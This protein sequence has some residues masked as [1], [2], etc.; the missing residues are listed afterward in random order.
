[1]VFDVNPGPEGSLYSGA[2]VAE[3]GG[4]A[5]FA[6]WD[7][8]THQIWG[9]TQDLE[10]APVTRLPSSIH[11]LSPIGLHVIG[12]RLLFNLDDG[13]H[14]QE[15]WVT[16]GT[17]AGTRMLRDINVGEPGEYGLPGSG[18]GDYTLLSRTGRTFFLAMDSSGRDLWSTDGTPAGTRKAARLRAGLK[19]LAGATYTRLLLWIEDAQ[20]GRELWASDGSESGASLVRDVNPGPDGSDPWNL[21]SFGSAALMSASDGVHGAELWRTDGTPAGTFLVK[22]IVPGAGSSVPRWFVAA[23]GRIYFTAF[24]PYGCSLWT[25]DGTAEGTVVVPGA[26]GLCPTQL[27]PSGRRLFFH[28]YTR[29]HGSELWALPLER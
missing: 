17:P 20:T 24:D 2:D 7:G 8:R 16:D 26:E 5:D 25:T 10:A 11:F 28:A 18:A 29:E 15:P 21:A 23:G 19:G 13:P 12:P 22:D 4:A 27:V 14:G 1:M 6:A 3:L 9:I